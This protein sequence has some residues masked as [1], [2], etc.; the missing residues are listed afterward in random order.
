[1]SYV[2]EYI[3]RG[4]STIIITK[5]ERDRPGEDEDEEVEE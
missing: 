3:E 4:N 2:R 5:E 1:M